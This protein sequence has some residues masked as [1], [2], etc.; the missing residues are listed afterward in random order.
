MDLK[1]TLYL[2]D[3]D[4]TLITSADRVH[5]KNKAGDV[6]NALSTA[7]FAHYTPAS[8]ESF[9]FSE[10]ND[11]DRRDNMSSAP[12]ASG[13]TVLIQVM[14]DM[15]EDDHVGILTARGHQKAIAREINE[16]CKNNGLDPVSD[17]FVFAVNDADTTYEG[18]SIPDKKKNVI[19]KML[20]F[21]KTVILVDDDERNLKAAETW[22]NQNNITNGAG[23][24]LQLVDP[25]DFNLN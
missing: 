14:E 19:K 4:D 10:F 3:I 24:R 23:G 18:S 17:E 7:E 25:K 13:I 16:I 8:D 1:G 11:P 12:T 6:I 20:N 21:F 9:D 15:G 22:A 5:V 2:F